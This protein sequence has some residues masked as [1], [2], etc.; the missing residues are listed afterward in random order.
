MAPA[1]PIERGSIW[2]VELSPAVGHEQ[3][4]KRP[5]MVISAPPMNRGRSGLVVVAV[6]TGQA[7]KYPSHVLAP[8]AV[9][10]AAHDGTV[11]CEHLHTLS[12]DRMDTR[13]V[14]QA[15]AAV[16]ALVDASIRRLLAL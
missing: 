10:G 8:A 9:T 2:W 3:A 13:P 7:S 14:G 5:V 15:N 12:V 11:M 6:M 16:M 1:V 4:G